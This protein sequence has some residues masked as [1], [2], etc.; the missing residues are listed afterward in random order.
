[1]ET[2]EAIVGFSIEAHISSIYGVVGSSCQENASR[3]GL[4]NVTHTAIAA[5]LIEAMRPL[6]LFL[7]RDRARADTLLVYNTASAKPVSSIVLALLSTCL[8]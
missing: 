2:I 3:K 1:M 5:S 4:P 8:A 6:N 7:P